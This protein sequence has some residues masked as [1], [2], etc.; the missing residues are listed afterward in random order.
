MNILKNLDTYELA[1]V[2]SE[3]SLPTAPFPRT[4]VHCVLN[5]L[6][7]AVL[8]VLSLRAAGYPPN[9]IHVLA[10]WDFVDAVEHQ[11]R[12]Q[13]GLSRMLT[14]LWS[15]LDEGLGDVYLQEAQR[16]HHILLVRLS[17]HEQSEQVSTLLAPYHAHLMKYVDTWAVADLSV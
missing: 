16:G 2:S 1:P 4:Y 8:C 12:Q 5:E 6:R 13:P 3:R 7:D 17:R 15:C 10:S 9:D 11:R 14:R